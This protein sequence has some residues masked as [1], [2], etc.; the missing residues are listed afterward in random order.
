[1]KPETF[2]DCLRRLIPHVETARIAL[3]GGMAISLHADRLTDA[4]SRRLTAEDI[5]FVAEEVEAVRPTAARD[6]LISHFHL[7]Q[8]GYPK[9]MI[10]IADPVTRLRVDFFPDSLGALDRAPLVD[11]GGVQL[12]VLQVRDLLAHK[13]TLLSNAS[14][15]SPI[16]RKHYVDAQRL[17]VICGRTLPPAANSHFTETA[18]SQNREE[19][20]RRCQTSRCDAFPLASKQAIFDV[21]GYV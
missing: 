2:H 19:V 9:F 15:T 11:V 21:L 17:A 5:D 16:E 20:C 1:M 7:P 8:P 14:A 3:T 18:F 4:V 12:R 6:F 10:Q 13:L